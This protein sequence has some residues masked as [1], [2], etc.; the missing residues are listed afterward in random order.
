MF[1]LARW[2]ADRRCWSSATDDCGRPGGTAPGL[3]RPLL[4]QASAA[5]TMTTPAAMIQNITNPAYVEEALRRTP[6]TSLIEW[7]RRHRPP[8]T[9]PST[10]STARTTTTMTTMVQSM[11]PSDGGG[12]VGHTYPEGGRFNPGPA[13]R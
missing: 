4:H 13:R 9:L 12:D 8:R 7:V 10:N 11:V 6:R 5:S 1:L 2:P 3:D